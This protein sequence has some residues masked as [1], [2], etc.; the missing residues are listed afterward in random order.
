MQTKAILRS[1]RMGPRKVRLLVDL[2]RGMK[3]EK[4]INQLQFSK[5][6]AAKPVLKLLNSAIANAEHNHGMNRD[7]LV[8]KTAFVDSGATLHRWTPRAMGRAT[9]IR[10]RTAHITLILEGVAEKAKAK[11]EKKVKKVSKKVNKEV[12]EVEGEKV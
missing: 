9:P 8:I 1:L 4:A 11:V 12:E 7:S 10:K 2:I 5:K 6:T 3:V